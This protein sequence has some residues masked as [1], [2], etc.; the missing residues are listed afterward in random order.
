MSLVVPV[1]LKAA[2]VFLSIKA[3]WWLG[4]A[5]RHYKAIFSDALGNSLNDS[6]SG[7][8]QTNFTRDIFKAVVLL[9]R[10]MAVCGGLFVV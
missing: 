5:G 9:T 8:V 2:D 10:L 3:C 7:L 6:R 4:C 1:S